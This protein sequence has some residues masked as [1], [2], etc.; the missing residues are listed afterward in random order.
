[1]AYTVILD[2]PARKALQKLPHETQERILLALH[3]LAET[4]RPP[5]VKKLAGNKE[6]LY[7]IRVGDYRILYHIEDDRLIVLVVR[8]GHRRDVYR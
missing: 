8:I 5:N 7:R 2:D 1:M 4:P 6:E 3:L